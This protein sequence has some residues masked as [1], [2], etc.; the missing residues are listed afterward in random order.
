MRYYRIA[1]LEPCP[2]SRLGY[3]VYCKQKKEFSIVLMKKTIEDY[4]DALTA[5]DFDLAIINPV[6]IDNGRYDERVFDFLEHYHQCF[7]EKPLAIYTDNNEFIELYSQ[8]YEHPWIIVP[9]TASPAL[10]NRTMT[11]L[12][13]IQRS[14]LK[15]RLRLTRKESCIIRMMMD[16]F[17]QRQIAEFSDCSVKTISRHKVNALRKLL[18]PEKVV[19]FSAHP[20]RMVSIPR[21]LYSL[22]E[23]AVEE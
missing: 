20:G 15:R 13:A 2:L 10:L 6:N 12:H 18:S 21:F 8:L 3:Q 7:V 22:E 5:Y 11:K 1:V 4:R 16:G 19:T 17:N 9:K 14:V 23:G